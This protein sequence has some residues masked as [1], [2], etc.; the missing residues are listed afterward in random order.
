MLAL[1]AFLSSVIFPFFLPKTRGGRQGEEMSRPGMLLFFVDDQLFLE[2]LGHGFQIMK[3]TRF[4]P[5]P[6]Q[7][8]PGFG[9]VALEKHSKT[10]QTISCVV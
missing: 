8:K 10:V 7:S 1:L 6:E 2:E 4:L 9:S 5:F 3:M